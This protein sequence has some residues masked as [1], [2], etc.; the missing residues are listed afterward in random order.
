M[1]ASKQISNIKAFVTDIAAKG[2]FHLLGANGLSRLFS[3][4]SQLILAW[5]FVAEDLGRIKSMQSFLSV[6]VVL[7]GAGF[8]VSTLKLTS[9]DRS[10]S[11]KKYLFAHAFRFT[12]I[13]AALVYLIF[14]IISSRGIFTDDKQTN[15]LLWIIALAVIPHAIN[16]LYLA[17]FQ[18]LK[19]LKAYAYIQVITNAIGIAIVLALSWF[20]ALKGYVLAFITASLLTMI[21]I[22]VYKRKV[23]DRQT[24]DTLKK[25]GNPLKQHL[26][27][28]PYSMMANFSSILS[29]NLD[30]LLLNF[31]DAEARMIGYYAFAKIFINILHIAASTVQQATNPFFSSLAEQPD[32][33]LLRYRKYNQVMLAA[34]FAGTIVLALL[35]PLFIK[36]LFPPYIDSIPFF[37][38]LLA[39]WLFR[40]NTYLP[41]SG[42]FGLGKINI[43]FF[44]SLS[45]L[46]FSALAMYAGYYLYSVTGLACGMAS[47][48]LFLFI[49]NSIIF[50]KKVS[51]KRD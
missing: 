8:N 28:A 40:S 1:S 3:F 4:G 9:E 27:Y 35:V 20:F 2:F 26:R 10:P 33:F 6:L 29:T 11:E 13:A 32:K 18:A 41:A 47:T 22:L 25:A 30:I 16:Q 14:V 5:I 17:Y 36:F 34:T 44:I 43:N 7:A 15:E 46:I 50:H 38:I 48:G 19:K 49:I 12:V 45:G 31:L 21:V 42:F 23:I 39:G 37:L 24:P 51:F